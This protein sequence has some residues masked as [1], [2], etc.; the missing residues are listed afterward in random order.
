[1]NSSL[2]AKWTPSVNTGNVAGYSSTTAS[3]SA[4]IWRLSWDGATIGLVSVNC[5]CNCDCNC[6]CSA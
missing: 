1:L 6:S 2:A 3:V 5:V 4:N